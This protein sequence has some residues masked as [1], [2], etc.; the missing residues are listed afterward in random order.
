M[1]SA[2]P[3]HLGHTA[4]LQ[5]NMQ[6]SARGSPT[7][8]LQAWAKLSQAMLNTPEPQATVHAESMTTARLSQ[9]ISQTPITF[10]AATST[11]HPT[12]G[13]LF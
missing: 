4:R 6:F 2:Q 7:K 11:Q 5:T 9:R 3:L 8:V 1:S 12:K 10:T 13:P